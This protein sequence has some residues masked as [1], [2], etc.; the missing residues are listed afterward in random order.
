MV[1][2]IDPAKPGTS[3]S[4]KFSIETAAYMVESFEIDLE[5]AVIRVPL[6]M[7]AVPPFRADKI[8]TFRFSEGDSDSTPEALID[9]SA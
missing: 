5:L 3:L 9:V 7:T 8:V 2:S 6:A 4:I 1:P